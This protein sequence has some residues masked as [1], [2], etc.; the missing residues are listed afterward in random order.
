MTG[1]W[2]RSVTDPQR[3][4]YLNKSV[5]VVLDANGNGTALLK[6]DVGQ[7]W[8]PKFI[9][10]STLNQVT[11][12][13]YC[14]T[15]HG[16]VT[17]KNQTTFLDDTFLGNGDTSS[18]VSGTVVQYGEAI[19]AVWTG[20][21]AGDTA[22]LTIYGVTLNVPPSVGEMPSVP[23]THFAGKPSTELT[24]EFARVPILTPTTLTFQTSL[25]IPLAS[26][27]TFDVRNFA[28]YYFKIGVKATP[29]AATAYN[30]FLVRLFWTAKS[31]GTD[32]IYE[33]RI[34]FWSDGNS[35]GG[36]FDYD[37]GNIILQDVHHGPYMS[38]LLVNRA[39][40]DSVSLFYTL[41]GT[42]RQLPGPFF[43]QNA[44]VASG[45]LVNGFLAANY[46]IGA[47]GIKEVPFHFTYGMIGLQITNPSAA[48]I[49]FDMNFADVPGGTIVGGASLGT[50][51]AGGV[52]YSNFIMPK[53]SGIFKATGAVGAQFGVRPI[54]QYNKV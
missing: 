36:S 25:N 45:I 2:N 17:I 16:A 44:A 48:A 50:I 40:A 42:S 32:V 6:P 31:D 29:G 5:S 49:S 15:Y 4:D 24:K 38:I 43:R 12:V 13:A 37:G 8:A 33:D 18:I 52:L 34:A 1:A 51:A 30:P 54:T 53:A 7:W 41:T 19:T 28:S 26:N 47:G 14:A 3:A 20:G 46:V 21:N 11:P 39:N 27:Q 23:G 9:R 10:V 35:F 22:V